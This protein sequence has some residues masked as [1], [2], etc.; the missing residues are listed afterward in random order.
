MAREEIHAHFLVANHGVFSETGFFR[1]RV[2]LKWV[3]SEMGFLEVG[4]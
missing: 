4:F 2:F 1:H 3:F